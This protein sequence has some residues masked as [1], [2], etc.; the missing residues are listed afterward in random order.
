MERMQT[1][2]E[3][4]RLSGLTF[5][6]KPIDI[7]LSSDA[8]FDNGA[9]AGIYLAKAWGPWPQPLVVAVKVFGQILNPAHKEILIHELM[10]ASN[11]A[12]CHPQVLPFI[13]TVEIGLQKGLVSLYMRNGNLLQYLKS[14]GNCDK[15]RLVVRVAEAV[16][17]L[18]TVASLV[19]GD[20]KCANVL[21]SDAGDALLGDFGLSTLVEKSEFD[22]TTMT[23]I[24]DMHTA[25]FAAPE[26][27]LGADNL[28]AK[29]R[30][31]TRESDVYA[32]GMLVLEALTGAPPWSTQSNL[33]VIQKVCSAQIQ[34]RPMLDGTSVSM[35]HTWRDTCRRCWSFEPGDRP[36]M[37]AILNIVRVSVLPF[38][39]N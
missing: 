30:S 6:G 34:P 28:T 23:G 35:S 4:R 10:T 16:N 3:P 20:L 15:K 14:H 11:V 21:V 8:P 25:R 9:S 27:L 22:P 7:E 26:L 2:L 38:A 18:H 19:H 36:P 1:G 39:G 32:F 24:R 12:L 33:S 13:G 17:Y 31:K 5:D 29:P 37:N